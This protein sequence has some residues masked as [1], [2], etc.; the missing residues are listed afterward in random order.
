MYSR[1]SPSSRSAARLA[2]NDRGIALPLA[3][4]MSRAAAPSPAGPVPT[5]ETPDRLTVQ[6]GSG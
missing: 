3:G 2:S 5:V 6:F 4:L 1:G